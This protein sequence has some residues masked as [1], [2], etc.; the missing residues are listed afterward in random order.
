[1]K[2]KNIVGNGSKATLPGG[3]NLS[4]KIQENKTK[5]GLNNNQNKL[6]NAS[7][8][9]MQNSSSDNEEN[10]GEKKKSKTDQAIQQGG[11]E[12]ARIAL[13]TAAASNPYTAW[14]PKGIR[15]K[16]VDKVVDSNLGQKVIEKQGKKLK[17]KM[18]MIVIS[19]VG[20]FVLSILLISTIAALI[21]A[22][23]SAINDTLKKTG[24][25]FVSVWNIFKYGE[26][27]SSDAECQEKLSNKYYDKLNSSVE[28]AFKDCPLIDQEQVRN[29]IT[30]TIFYDQMMYNSNYRDFV[31]DDNSGES[32]DNANTETETD[33]EDYSDLIENSTGYFDYRG[34]I[35]HI[36]PLLNILKSDG[37]CSLN[38]YSYRNHLKNKYIEENYNYVLVEHYKDGV[39]GN[40]T[41][42]EVVEEI[43]MI[44][45]FVNKGSNGSC[46]NSC[47]YN[48]GGEQ[49][50]N[51]KVRLIYGMYTDKPGE[52]IEGEELVPFEKYILGVVY[53]EVGSSAND[54]VL[55]AQAIAAR[56]FA[57]T[58]GPQMGGA[59]GLGLH[60][61]NG[62]WILTIRSST[63]DQVYC[64]PDKGC[65]KI[66][67]VDSTVFSDPDKYNKYKGPL[68][69]DA[70]IRTVVNEVAGKVVLNSKGE[71]INT[72]YTNVQQNLWTEKANAGKDYSI[73]L[74]ESYSNI[75]SIDDGNCSALCSA[76]SGAYT[77]WKQ[78][79]WPDV[80]MN[81]LSLADAGCLTVSVCMQVARSGVNTP[82]GDDFNPGTLVQNYRNYLYSGYDNWTWYG[83]ESVIPNFVY[84]RSHQM[85]EVAGMDEDKLIDELIAGINDGCYYVVEVKSYYSG[86]HWVAI[87]TIQNG[88]IYIM[89]PASDCKILS[90]CKSSSTGA[91]YKINYAQCY[92]VIEGKENNE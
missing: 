87:D 25:F 13:K 79:S 40:L 57:L 7:N 41:I 92:K 47:S 68:A 89:D 20:S 67:G 62:Q 86:Q 39:E 8:F 80:Y 28:N 64:D 35:E 85:A 59:L 23:V 43:M 78:F 76:A 88:E 34:K 48:I 54:E 5:Q 82:L 72:P 83:I 10:N 90:Q 19:I 77:E 74:K 3:Q 31:P 37:S 22:P 45:G 4:D 38:S 29:L 14:I 6:N 53:A 17:T 84:D 52:P 46:S 42:D 1:M 91:P 60:N 15:D 18:I 26:L 71:I 75:A 12:A 70:K 56:S 50:S 11:T 49:V 36:Q 81:N 69:A 58:R 24:D 32:D 30:G 33:S 51:I 2:G 73:I 61:E 44:G 21:L 66:G 55:K 65:S 16:I 27:C 9:N 63:E